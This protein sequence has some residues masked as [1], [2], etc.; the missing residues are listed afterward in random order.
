MSSPSN[1]RAIRVGPSNRSAICAVLTLLLSV[2][3][4]G[5]GGLKLPAVLQRGPVAT[6]PNPSPGWPP[7]QLPKVKAGPNSVPAVAAEGNPADG[8][9]TDGKVSPKDSRGESK[10]AGTGQPTVRSTT[11][12]AKAEK[13]RYV[14]QPQDRI[15]V[16]FTY[17]PSLDQ[18]LVIQPDGMIA[19]PWLHPVR[20]AGQTPS[21][22]EASLR[23]S[24]TSV[25]R[26]PRPRV[27]VRS[28]GPRFVTVIGAVARPGLV[29]LRSAPDAVDAV[30]SAGGLRTGADPDR[31][32]RIR[33]GNGP[34]AA[35]ETTTVKPGT[36]SLVLRHNDVVYVPTLLESA[37][38]KNAS[39]SHARALAP[40]RQRGKLR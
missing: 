26:D 28:L 13:Q 20:A 12:S 8:K 24:L 22:L 3:A 40:R 34:G 30:A 38:R 35:M 29:D 1:R 15:A 10:S 11:R 7:A 23:Q 31:V 39:R 25:M 27:V 21:G 18:E 9:R 33:P 16:V 5:C 36:K 37:A 19:L 6:A 4:I 17:A 32:L 2:S 14:L